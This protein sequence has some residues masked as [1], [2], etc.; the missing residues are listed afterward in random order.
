MTILVFSMH[1]K[2]LLD[3]LKKKKGFF[4]AILD[5]TETESELSVDN[6]ISVLEQKKIL[7]SCIDEIDDKLKPFQSSLHYLSQEI[8]EELEVIKSIIHQIIHAD[9]S[10]QKKRKK[11]LKLDETTID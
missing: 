5:L 6:W 8:L 2:K 1:E 10:N 7:L 9:D 3:L 11:S 4:E